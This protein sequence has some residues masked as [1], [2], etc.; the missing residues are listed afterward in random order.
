MSSTCLAKFPSSI[1]QRQSPLI[2]LLRFRQDAISLTMKG[3]SRD[4]L[5]ITPGRKDKERV[6]PRTGPGSFPL[7][8]GSWFETCIALPTG[9]RSLKPPYR[10]D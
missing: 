3:P 6:E 2:L 8:G 5:F 9:A 7:D 1:D 4:L 10:I